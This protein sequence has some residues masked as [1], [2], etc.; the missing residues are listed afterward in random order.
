MIEI[1]RAGE[2]VSLDLLVSILFKIF[3]KLENRINLNASE[4]LCILAVMWR[5]VFF[6]FLIDGF[7]EFI[8]V[9]GRKVPEFKVFSWF[10][11][12]RVWVE[13]GGLKRKSPYL[14]QILEKTNQKK[15]RI[16]AFFTH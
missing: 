1:A 16:W 8:Y 5:D 7:S 15:P 12:S 4:M 2:A 10:V 9:G 6:C 13:Y 3:Q 14:V 11:F